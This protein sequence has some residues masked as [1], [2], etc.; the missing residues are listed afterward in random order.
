MK[1]KIQPKEYVI[2]LAHGSRHRVTITKAKYGNGRL[3]LLL[4]SADGSP[5][6]KA[7]V[8]LADEEKMEANEIAVKDYS[9]NEGMLQFLMANG[10]VS[11]PHRYG[12]SGWAKIPICR[13]VEGVVL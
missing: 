7:T 11:A 10:I 4:N 6:A 12:E 3:A 1:A 5:F 8:N 2:Q 9:E 13:L